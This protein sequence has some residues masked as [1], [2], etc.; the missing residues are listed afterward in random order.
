VYALVLIPA[1]MLFGQISD[2]I[3]RRPAIAIGLALATGALLLFACARSVAWP[4]AAPAVQGVAQGM[5][6]GA[7]I[8]LAAWHLAGGERRP[9]QRHLAG[10]RAMG[11]I[12]VARR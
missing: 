2:R 4:F 10:V 11:S 1:L 5:I 6:S 12:A 7:A 9:E 8:T 3:G